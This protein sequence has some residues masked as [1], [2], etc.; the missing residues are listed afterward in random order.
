MKRYTAMIQIVDRT[1]V[2][3][4]ILAIDHETAII[5]AKAFCEFLNKGRDTMYILIEVKE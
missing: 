5:K 4:Q 1:I 3:K 2:P